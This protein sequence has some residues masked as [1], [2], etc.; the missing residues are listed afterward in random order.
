MCVG[1]GGRE[2]HNGRG[3]HVKFYAYEKD[4]GGGGAG[5]GG[6]QNKF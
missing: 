3:E 4:G 6:L 1:G 2:L 5:D